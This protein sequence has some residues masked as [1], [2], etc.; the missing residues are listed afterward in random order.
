MTQ[1]TKSWLSSRELSR[2]T[3]NIFSVIPW[4]VFKK[5]CSLCIH[6]SLAYVSFCAFQ[7]CCQS[8][9]FSNQLIIQLIVCLDR[10]KPKLLR[11]SPTFLQVNSINIYPS[12]AG[13]PNAGEV[14]WGGLGKRKLGV[15]PHWETGLCPLLATEQGVTCLLSALFLTQPKG[16]GKWSLEAQRSTELCPAGQYASKRDRAPFNSPLQLGAPCVPARGIS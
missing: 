16:E 10:G 15:C 14:G 8:P 7:N 1:R 3:L 2:L 4:E 12:P 6:L 13:F 11:I 5:A 9:H